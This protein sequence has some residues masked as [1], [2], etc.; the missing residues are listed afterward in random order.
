MHSHLPLHDR[1][2]LS[3]DADRLDRGPFIESLVRS[4]VRDLLDEKGEVKGRRATGYVVGLTGRWGSGKSSVLN[5]LARRLDELDHVIVAEFN[6]WIF[7]G[8]DEL[9]SGFFNALRAAMGRSNVE[10]GLALAKAVERYWG[11]INLAGHGVAAAVDVGGGM[12][13]ATAGWKTWGP[14]FKDFFSTPKP[15]TPD[16]ERRALE[17]KLEQEHCAVVVLIDELDRVEDAEV[18]AV[19]QLVKAVGDIKGLSYLVAYDHD[20]VAEALG[21]GK[22]DYGE[23]YLEKIV[24]HPIPLRP[25]LGNDVKT[26]IQSAVSEQKLLLEEPR[27]D[28][29]QKIID[30]LVEKISTPRDVKRLLGTFSILEQAVRAE[31]CPYDVLGYSWIVTKAPGLRDAI[32]TGIDKVVIDPS[33]QGM[34]ELISRRMDGEND[35]DFIQLLGQA[36][37]EHTSML[38]LL[39]PHVV[40]E[41]S[42]EHGD[43]LFKR[44]NLVRML[45]LG[46]PPGSI[47]RADVEAIWNTADAAVLET[48]LQ[49]KLDEGH[50]DVLIDRLDDLL[51][52]LPLGGDETFW[53]T[54]SKIFVRNTDWITGPDPSHGLADD[55]ATALYRLGLRNKE[56]APRVRVALDALISAGDF[57]FVPWILRKHL[58][59]HGLT[60]S[61]GAARGDWVLDK[62]TTA[63]LLEREV[64]RYRRAALDGYALRRLPTG[65]V[66][67]LLK[68]SGH[69]DAELRDSLTDQLDNLSA[70]STFAALVVPPGYG[71]ERKSLDEFFD[72]AKILA[73]IDSFVS[74]GTQPADPWLADSLARLRNVLARGD[75]DLDRD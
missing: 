61:G 14:R 12:G 64:P 40:D 46:D 49:Q 63:Q 73:R 17:K 18:R 11:A 8:R 54:L 59:A 33:A 6:P 50:L 24:Q 13:A 31:I 20:R 55:A 45:Y 10:E 22:P 60:T 15:R 1:P 25:L 43:R 9:F 32:A 58:F 65:E 29:Q 36:A 44:R 52:G 68:N 27:T 47:R 75:V 53:P 39:F 16:D 42:P 57:V 71:A 51:P 26:L 19:A 74:T 67:Y 3:R 37:A 2:I 69:W 70:L 5:L 34:A 48:S 21:G 4:L 41:V 62:A 66:L 35:R 56:R 28:N 7:S 23:R 38:S 30:H 72:A